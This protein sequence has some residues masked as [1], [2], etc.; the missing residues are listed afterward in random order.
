MAVIAL[1]D[2]DRVALVRQYRHAV[3]YRLIEPPA[4]LLDVDGEDYLPAARRELA[5]EVGLGADT[6]HVL[7]DVFTTPGM[8]SEAIRVYLARG[9]SEAA[10]PES[11]LREG[12]EAHMDIVW[13]ALDDLVSAVL[14]GSGAEPHAGRRRARHLDGAAAGRVR[15][16]AARGRAL[17]GSGPAR[18]RPALSVYPRH[19]IDLAGGDVLTGLRA[20]V[21]APD[22]AALEADVLQAA[23]MTDRGLVCLSVRSAWDLLLRV[24]AWPAGSEVIV[25]AITHP[26]MITIAQGHGL[27]A[28]PVDLDLATLAPRVEDLEQACTTRTR[29]VMIVH[30]FGGRVDLRPIAD[31]A[32]RHDL[33]LVE[34][35]A[36]AFTGTDSL[37][38]SGADVSMFSFGM[39]KTASAVGGALVSVDDAE[40]RSSMRKEQDDWPALPRIAYVVRLA[41]AGGLAVF[42]D[43]RRF[44]VLFG[45]CRRLGVDLDSMINTS[46]RSFAAGRSCGPGSGADPLPRCSPCCIAGSGRSTRTGWPAAPRWARSCGP[47][48]R[49]RTCIRATSCGGV[50]TGCSRCWPPTRSHWSPPCVMPG[51]T[52]A[53]G[54]ATW[55]R[56]RPTTARCR[57]APAG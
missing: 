9:L 21:R 54:P 45:L 55:S 38:P 41:K 15:E 17:A 5:E 20:T 36:Q 10:A 18:G 33:L 43:P 26:D 47:A 14:C 49:R 52:S 32:R 8:L 51:S 30:L 40:L 1:D 31:F 3:G 44:G 12:E 29:A 19:R 48:C 28:V 34:D 27:R 39:I 53:P 46:T 2:H 6:W 4:G 22:P 25:S 37:A 42:N 24:L 11:F 57:T 23:G 7:A 56:C 16:P 13:A 35:S 50:P